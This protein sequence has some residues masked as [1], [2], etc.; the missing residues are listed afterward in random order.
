[1]KFYDKDFNPTTGYTRWQLFLERNPSCKSALTDVNVLLVFL[2]DFVNMHTDGI[3]TEYINT[4][5]KTGIDFIMLEDPHNYPA[6]PEFIKDIP[7]KT[8]LLHNDFTIDNQVEV[9]RLYWP[10]WLFFVQDKSEQTP[11]IKSTYPLSCANRNICYRPGKIY[12]YQTLKNKTYFDK[13]LFTKFKTESKLDCHWPRPGDA[14]F[15]EIFNKLAIDYETWPLIDNDLF[16]GMA[17][18]NLP[19]YTNSLFHMVAESGVKENLI[20]EKTY[21]IFH[22]K[23]IPILC[24]ARNTMAHLQSIG[25]DIF[26]DIIDHSA[27]DGIEDFKRRIDAMQN[28]AETIFNLDHEKLISKTLQRRIQNHIWLHS[29]QL[30]DQLVKPI[31]ARLMAELDTFIK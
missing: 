13:I 25:F 15:E 27:Y 2:R 11:D 22:V 29:Q 12:N 19:V 20:S 9:H 31:V 10:V 17:A 18:V 4:A 23:Q 14:E 1:M 30:T 5:L 7:I 24:G 8:F 21:K 16:E 28:T 26:D 3:L 6:V